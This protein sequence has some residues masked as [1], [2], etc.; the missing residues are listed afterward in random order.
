MRPFAPRSRADGSTSPDP[1]ASTPATRHEVTA[2]RR[3]ARR[4]R[5][6]I[7]SCAA[8]LA[9]VAGTGFA[10]YSATSGSP[11]GA[12][13]APATTVTPSTD[14]RLSVHAGSAVTKAT[15]NTE[16]EMAIASATQVARE[17][18]GKVDT[19]QLTTSLAS[20][21]DYRSLAP[22][23]VLARVATTKDVAEKVD[24]QT[25]V[26]EQRIAREK[27]TAA[28]NAA[29]AEAARVAAE[30]QAQANTP[31]GAKATAQALMASQY[32]W[33]S[34]QFSCLS[35]LWT[36]ESGWSYTAYNANGGATGIPQALP[37][38]KMAS[39]ASDWQTNATTQVIWGLRYIQGSY[40]TPCSAWAHSQANNWY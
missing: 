23:T 11:F 37:G 3:R 30:K 5:V 22:D 7:A 17:A 40:G 9:V 4:G 28:K 29:A 36:K 34:D 8:S 39:V 32:G 31:A 1:V 13:P 2:S 18:R 26:A 14:G 6:I 15:A 38:S 33:G 27:A 20:L 24:A 10:A 35:S 25:T 16:A 19:K 12:A 21:S